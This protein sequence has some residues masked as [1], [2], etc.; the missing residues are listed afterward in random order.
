MEQNYRFS[1]KELLKY[2]H[3][4]TFVSGESYLLAMAWLRGVDHGQK[5]EEDFALRARNC[6]DG[7]EAVLFT[8]KN[9]RA[10]KSDRDLYWVI[11][12]EGEGKISLYSEC[13]KKYLTL[14]DQGARLSKKKQLLTVTQNGELYQ[15]SVVKENAN[16]FLRATG[17]SESPDG[18]IFSSG[19][20]NYAC[21][22]ALLRRMHGISAKPAGEPKLTV[23]TF[24]DVH[25]DYGLQ[26]HR[27]YLR[28]SAIKTATA[29]R[30]RYNLDVLVNCGDNI[31]DNASGGYP[32]GGAMQGKWPRER[33]LKVQKLLHETMQKSFRDPAKANNILWLTG[34]H[35]TQVGDRQPEGQLFNSADYSAYMPETVDK[36]TCK[37]D[38]IDV[39]NDEHTLCYESRING[40]PFLVLCTP[41]YPLA[42]HIRIPD[43]Y[44]PAHTMEQVKWLEARLDKI[45]KEQG[46][47]TVVFVSSHYP[48]HQ[49]CYCP[50]NAECPDNR[51][52]FLHMH[53][54]LNRFPNL[55]FFYGH[56][57]GGDN[58]VDLKET[59]E[60]NV[61]YSKVNLQLTPDRGIV[62]TDDIA[63]AYFRSD[64]IV[65]TGFWHEFAGSLAYFKNTFFA[66]DGKKIDSWLG[67]LE[68]PFI[69]GCI[70]EVYDDRVVLTMQNTGTKKDL[71]DHVPNSNYNLKPFVI[72][73]IKD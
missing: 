1:Q 67:H 38:G 47:D 56:V 65:G 9:L 18:M 58:W 7:L 53:K 68:V 10:K 20:K 6:R 35:D 40:V 28:K 41:R 32:S 12:E 64:M 44:S 21:S 36:L 3:I 52:A 63:R 31:S 72:P 22:F 34:N 48:L 61:A 66:N 57:H 11:T 54:V 39:G 27:P 17:H 16:L 60:N 8:E 33:F 46:K 37:I 29:F 23:G 51:D 15:F 71:A 62:A 55:I 69:Q 49:W 50:T 25:I 19:K 43:R 42:S 70:A 24:S 59:S 5:R 4:P 14:D 13:A 73:L 45:E 30:N 2:R 26:L